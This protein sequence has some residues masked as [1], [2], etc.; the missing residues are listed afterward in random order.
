[1]QNALMKG[2]QELLS[3]IWIVDLKNNE[4]IRADKW[5][6]G[7]LMIGR[8]SMYSQ[9]KTA[10][11]SSSHVVVSGCGIYALELETKQ[12]HVDNNLAYRERLHLAAHA[13]LSQN[14]GE[15]WTPSPPRYA[16][17]VRMRSSGLKW[18]DRWELSPS[19]TAVSSIT[20]YVCVGLASCSDMCLVS[21][22][23]TNLV[24]GLSL[25]WQTHGMSGMLWFHS[26]YRSRFK[27]FKDS[28]V[29]ACRASCT[30]QCSSSH[31]STN[32]GSPYPSSTTDLSH[33]DQV[34]YFFPLG[35]AN[36]CVIMNRYSLIWLGLIL[37]ALR[38]VINLEYFTFVLCP[39]DDDDDDDFKRKR[40]FWAEGFPFV[41]D[42]WHLR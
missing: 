15:D 30:F 10:G 12:L 18:R 22:V 27:A 11:L 32:Q 21:Y 3:L 5:I 16:E 42:R 24:G 28:M 25:V 33:F 17:D 38:R 41:Q 7:F 20:A 19:P 34:A 35:F 4:V 8:L 23:R 31:S 6:F 37:M 1:M 29:S 2:L 39:E 40:K 9:A 36:L 14:Q 13:M 26:R